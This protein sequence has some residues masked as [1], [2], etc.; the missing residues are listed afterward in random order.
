MHEE[1]SGA[2]AQPD[3]EITQTQAEI[4]PI[5]PG[6]ARRQI[7]AAMKAHLGDDW[8]E[9]EDGWVVTHDGDYFVRLTRGKKNLDFQCDL[10]GEVTI[11]ERDISPVQDSGRLVA[12]SILIATLFVA[13]VI[14]QLAGALN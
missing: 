14:A 12:W 3:A 13:F 4:D 6:D 8:T 5:A 7:E 2:S 10:L 1:W 11:E 9:Q